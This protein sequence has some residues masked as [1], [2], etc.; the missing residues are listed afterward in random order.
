MQ[1]WNLG[2][3]HELPGSVVLSV[4]Y[5]A[6]KGT[7]L[8]R[9]YDLNQLQ[10]VPASQNPYITAGLPITGNDCQSNAANF[11][12][13]AQG[14]PTSAVIS[15]GAVL[16]QTAAQNLYVAC[17]YGASNYFRPYQG[18]GTITRL[19][20]TANSNY[21]SLQVSARR[22]VG[23]LSPAPT[24]PI[25]IRSMIPPI[26]VT[27][28]LS[29]LSMRRAAGPAPISTSATYLQSATYTRFRFSKSL[30]CSTLFWEA[31]SCRAS[32]RPRLDCL[33]PSPTPQLTATMR[34]W[35]TVFPVPLVLIPMWLGIPT[36]SPQPNNKLWRPPVSS[37]S[38]GI[39]RPLTCSPSASS[40]T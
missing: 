37:A 17:N 19:E 14:L 34:V 11:T 8:T 31:G 6:S 2:V 24:T 16:S 1:Q 5:V 21:N 9:E 36:P 30:A 7:H 18:W 15:N 10:A 32:P 4:A 23:A 33:L 22:S 39:I 13:N 26:A 27:L 12:L 20:N 38:L 3:E 40:N 29:I 35:L 25:A 28:C